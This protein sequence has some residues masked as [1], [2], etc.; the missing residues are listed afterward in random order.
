MSHK[1][2]QWE[3][4]F[5]TLAAALN[6]DLDQPQWKTKQLIKQAI[7]KLLDHKL[8]ESNSGIAR[9]SDIV[10]LHRTQ[11]AKQRRQQH[12]E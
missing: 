1:D 6:L 10:K 4:H 8:L 9:D 2:N 7:K 3:G 5:L 12:L 11:S